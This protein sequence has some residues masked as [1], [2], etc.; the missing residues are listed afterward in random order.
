MNCDICGDK[1]VGRNYG[2]ITCE[3]CKV[4]K[5]RSHGNCLL[6]KI[7]RRSCKSCRINKCYEMGMRKVTGIDKK[8]RI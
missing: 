7:T 1:S 3:S 5:C 6:N 4:G 2:A 8:S